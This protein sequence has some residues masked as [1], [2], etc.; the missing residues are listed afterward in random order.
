M[1]AVAYT[2]IDLFI[3][4]DLAANS[5]IYDQVSVVPRAR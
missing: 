1:V 5:V 3:C 2:T 4:V